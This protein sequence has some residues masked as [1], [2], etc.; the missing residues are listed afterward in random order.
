MFKHILFLLI[1]SLVFWAC[2]ED[3]ESLTEDCAG[4]LGGDNIC[5]CTDSQSSSYDSTAT[6]DDGSCDSSH[7][8]IPGRTIYIVCEAYNSEGI[9]TACYWVNC[10]RV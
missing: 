4:V 1:L 5:G 7:I 6:Y 8:L 10:V 2:A 3:E 9:R